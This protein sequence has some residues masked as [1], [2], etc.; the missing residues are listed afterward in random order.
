MCVY[1]RLYVGTAAR[2]NG[3]PH[4]SFTTC[5][6]ACIRERV[7]VRVRVRVCVRV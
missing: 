7:R 1:A 2:V 5:M 4:T 6:C 3:Q